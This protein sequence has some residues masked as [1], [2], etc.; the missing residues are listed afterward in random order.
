MFLL[1]EDGFVIDH[2][3]TNNKKEIRFIFV[4]RINKH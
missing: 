2:I 4:T 1:T 3:F